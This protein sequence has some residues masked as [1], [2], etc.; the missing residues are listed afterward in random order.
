M[1]ITYDFD[2]IAWATEQAR[3]LRERRISELDYDNIAEELEGMSRSQKRELKN[4]FTVLLM[5]L[6]KWQYQP[7]HRCKS[8]VSTITGQRR[9]IEMLID[10]MPSIRN[11]FDTKEW[12]LKAW[13]K[14]VDEASTETTIF[15]ENFPKICPWLI[16]EIL[17]EWFPD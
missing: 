11:E 13:D 12:Q 8:W 16:D 1:T 10:D 6:L 3:L 9:E 4:R 17:G 14:A 7:E 15:R 2:V 5:H